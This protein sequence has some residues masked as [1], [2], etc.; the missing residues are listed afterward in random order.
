MSGEGVVGNVHFQLYSKLLEFSD[1]PINSR[2]QFSLIVACCASERD[3]PDKTSL[4]SSHSL[5]PCR[6]LPDSLPRSIHS[7]FPTSAV[8]Y[9]PWEPAQGA[10]GVGEAPPDL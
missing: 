2:I 3:S 6:I 8:S 10:A 9:G 1:M 4:S 7:C 5:V